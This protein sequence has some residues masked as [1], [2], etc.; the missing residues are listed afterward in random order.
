MDKLSSIGS[1]INNAV[2]KSKENWK[3]MVKIKSDI[4]SLLMLYGKFLIHVLNE[5]GTELIKRSK[6]LAEKHL[7]AKREGEDDFENWA[8]PCALVEV[9][10]H[11]LEHGHIKRCNLMFSSV[12]GHYRDE[13]VDKKINILMPSIY[14]DVHD[15]YISS[16]LETLDLLGRKSSLRF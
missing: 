12:F 15:S 14:A 7:E 3:E 4:P 10:Y 16:Y 11:K 8:D 5:R 1:K 9:G 2:E 13:I 6:K